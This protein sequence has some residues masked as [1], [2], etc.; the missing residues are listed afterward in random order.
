LVL[1]TSNKNQKNL[2]FDE[3]IIIKLV[4]SI[5]LIIFT[6]IFAQIKYFL[7]DNPVPITLQTFGILLM[8][9]ILGPRW[10]FGSSSAYILLGI[11]GVPV[12]QGANSGFDYVIGVTGG[13]IVGF[14]PASFTVGILINKGLTNLTS[15]WPY[16]IGTI[17]IYI[18]AVIWLTVFDFSWPEDGKMLSQAVYPF[19][20]GDFI[21]AI[22][23]SIIT[24][25]VFK[26]AIKKF[27]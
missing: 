5:S 11:I 15:I 2:V 17:T 9:G 24:T 8:G 16:I 23:A 25:L 3:K 12:F 19:L 14:I 26:S 1:H 7:P 4:I 6:S 22:F 27:I 10:G 20:I 18:T 21:K 13:Y